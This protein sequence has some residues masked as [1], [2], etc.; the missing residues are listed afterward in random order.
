M[1]TE[2]Q[3]S[4][5]KKDKAD[6]VTHVSGQAVGGTS[7]IHPLETAIHNIENGLARYFVE[8]R[9]RRAEVIVVDTPRKYLRTT[10]D[11]PLYNNLEKLDICP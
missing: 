4:C 3:I 8:V 5:I 7:W 11:N 6:R 1:S 2:L 9:G 10:A